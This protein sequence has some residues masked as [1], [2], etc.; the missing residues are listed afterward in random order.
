[1]SDFRVDF[2]H[3]D[4]N[5]SHT[6][7]ATDSL[8]NIRY[9]RLHA[10]HLKTTRERLCRLDNLFICCFQGVTRCSNTKFSRVSIS[11]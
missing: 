6:L 1:M 9:S 3:K 2:H 11:H 10:W 7:T 8:R 5:I 4:G